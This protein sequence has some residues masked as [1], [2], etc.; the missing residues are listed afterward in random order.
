LH[1]LISLACVSSGHN[2]SMTDDEKQKSKSEEEEKKKAPKPTRFP[3]KIGEP[4]GNLRKREQW[5]RKR[6]GS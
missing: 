6:S 5:F 4:P 2:N 3:R 1:F